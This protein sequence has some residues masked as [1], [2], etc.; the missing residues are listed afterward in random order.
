[1]GAMTALG[2]ESASKH[3][4]NATALDAVS[5][6]FPDGVITAIIGRRVKFDPVLR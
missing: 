5:L 6:Q 3:Y 1:M 4:D 2:I